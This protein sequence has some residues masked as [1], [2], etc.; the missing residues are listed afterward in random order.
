MYAPTNDADEQTKED[1]YGKLQEVAEQVH[2]HDMLIITG[3]M[4]AKV[5]N[6]VNGLKSNGTTRNEHGY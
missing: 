2:K 4:N 6:L 1:F 5:G 3:D